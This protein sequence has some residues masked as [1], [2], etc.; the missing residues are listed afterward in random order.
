MDRHNCAWGEANGDG[1]PDL[2]CV[3]GTEVGNNELWLNTPDGFVESA[4][5]YGLARPADRARTATWIDY[6]QD[7]DLDLFLG[8][9]PASGHPVSATTRFTVSSG[10]RTATSTF[11]SRSQP[12]AAPI[13]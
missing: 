4:D 9:V 13:R 10:A 8:N 2:L 11:G 12:L 7:G 1:R 3:Q 6:D 5:A